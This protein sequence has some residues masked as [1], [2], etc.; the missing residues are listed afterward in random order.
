GAPHTRAPVVAAQRRPDIDDRPSERRADS[1]S[2][3]LVHRR[4]CGRHL[5]ARPGGGIALDA[6]TS[7]L[8]VPLDRGGQRFPAGIRETTGSSGARGRELAER[9]LPG[10]SSRRVRH[11]RRSISPLPPPPAPACRPA[12]RPPPPSPPG[13]PAGL[14]LPA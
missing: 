1:L 10:A 5:R 12:M 9:A 7:L 14:P 8:H 11:T 13:S 4:E 6:G 3:W 2:R